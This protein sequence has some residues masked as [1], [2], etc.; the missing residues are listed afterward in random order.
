MTRAET[1]ENARKAV[2]GERENEYGTPEDNFNKIAGLWTAYL[3][4]EV[5][6]DAVDVAMMMSLLKIARVK[7]GHG[8]D[9]SFVDLAG[10]A[11]CGAEIHGRIS[12]EA[13][14]KPWDDEPLDIDDMLENV[15]KMTGLSEDD[16]RTRFEDACRDTGYDPGRAITKFFADVHDYMEEEADPTVIQASLVSVA[17]Q[18]GPEKR[19][20]G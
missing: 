18:P 19:R 4:Y 11:A 13:D 3:G 1:L 10:Y 5:L 16:V 9:D 14:E 20:E 8:S 2:C 7:S 12:E 15:S 17:H 6:L